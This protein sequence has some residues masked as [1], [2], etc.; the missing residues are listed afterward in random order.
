MD[1]YKVKSLKNVELV[2]V[3]ASLLI[4]LLACLF[5]SSITSYLLLAFC[6]TKLTLLEICAF[7]SHQ[8]C[9][10]REFFVISSNKHYPALVLYLPSSWNQTGLHFLILGREIFFHAHLLLLPILAA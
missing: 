5:F 4:S 8:F 3:N 1:I 7:P 10:R 9:T 6:Q 2:I